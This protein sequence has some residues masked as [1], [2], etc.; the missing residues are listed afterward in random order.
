MTPAPAPA[1]PATTATT[2]TSTIKS[3]ADTDKKHGSGGKKPIVRLRDRKG[4]SFFIANSEAGVHET[5]TK[6]GPEEAVGATGQSEELATATPSP[7]PAD[8]SPPLEQEEE[9]TVQELRTFSAMAADENGN[10]TA[11]ELQIDTGA[12]GDWVSPAAVAAWRGDNPAAFP[13]VALPT[14][15]AHTAG[16][17]FPSARGVTV[18]ITVWAG[19]ATHEITTTFRILERA[20]ATDKVALIGMHCLTTTPALLRILVERIESTS[21]DQEGWVDDEEEGIDPPPPPP[22][23]AGELQREVAQLLDEFPDTFSGV[24]KQGGSDLP[25]M[26]IP[27]KADA[28][29]Q[30]TAP[31]G[32][33]PRLAAALMAKV[34]ELEAKGLVARVDPSRQ[35]IPRWC[36]PAMA[37]SKTDGTV[38]LV[39]DYSRTN[40]EIEYFAHPLPIQEELVARL[41]GAKYFSKIDLR[42]AFYQVKIDPASRHVTTFHTPGGLYQYTVSP[43]GLSLS[44]GWLQ[45]VIEELLREEILECAVAFLDDVVVYS[46][47]LEEHREHVRRVLRKFDSVSL[48]VNPAKC[49]FFQSK[50]TFLG[51][52]VDSST[53]SVSAD[54]C[55]DLRALA[56]PTNKKELKAL[57]GAFGFIRAFLPNYAAVAEPLQQRTYNVQPERIDASDP[58]YIAEI[59]ALKDLIASVPVL[60]HPRYDHLIELET[61]ASAEGWGAVLSQRIDGQK[62]IIAFA[63]ARFRGA[64]LRWTSQDREMA[65][66]V[67]AILRWKMFLQGQHFIVL[68]DCRNITFWSSPS[69]SL[70]VCRWREKLA[71]FQFSI[72]HVPGAQNITADVLSRLPPATSQL[73]ATQ[74][75]SRTPAPAPTTAE[76]TLFSTQE[77]TSAT[78]TIPPATTTVPKTAADTTAATDS[79][80]TATAQPH[81][82]VPRPSLHK[83]EEIGKAHNSLVGHG[84]VQKT[85]DLLRQRGQYWDDMHNDVQRFVAACNVCQKGNTV[86]P[87]APPSTGLPYE[88]GCYSVNDK[89]AIDLNV[90]PKDDDGYEYI[91]VMEDLFTRFVLLVPLKSKTAAEVTRALMQWAGLFGPPR[92]LL[93]DQGREFVSLMV[94][95]LLAMMGTTEEYTRAGDHRQNGIVE[96]S[97]REVNRHLLAIVQ[98]LNKRAS[99][100]EAVPVVQYIMNGSRTTATGIAPAELMFGPNYNAFQILGVPPSKTPKFKDLGALQTAHQEMLT[101]SARHIAELAKAKVARYDKRHPDGPTT[102][103]PD[104]W[105]LARWPDNRRPTKLHPHWRGPF[106]F[107]EHLSR[108]ES[109]L[110]DIMLGKDIIVHTSDLLA[111]DDGLQEDKLKIRAWDQHETPVTSI[112]DHKPKPLPKTLKDRQYL[113]RFR[114]GTEEWKDYLEVRDLEAFERYEA[115]QSGDKSASP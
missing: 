104:S 100:H 20:T 37:L 88:S 42:E 49:A 25:P 51:H 31:R 93:S 39:V 114:D 12:D 13:I 79:S 64:E 109:R 15:L 23:L 6:H 30:R 36:A 47:T 41:A 40:N 106:Q 59:D 110:R 56:T 115:N 3:P 33:A 29:P 105:V 80:N 86:G 112:V 77:G 43:M 91:A 11:A 52:D 1:G 55:A 65:A 21:A 66:V 46:E 7:G 84:G 96:R 111:Y 16:G 53:V 5:D 76:T 69:A 58:T 4:K 35:G 85:L 95:E 70:R 72:R 62:C 87:R 14:V 63:S 90:M 61:D 45:G 26:P 44:P 17:T 48:R 57:L 107:I 75:T 18:T 8:T 54:R 101:I 103:D 68:T 89:V 113:V 50:I 94:K 27:L 67:K 92:V 9:C 24:I 71:L 102:F 38:R 32:M 19:G 10:T 82:L 22:P 28:V 97:M 34:H 98:T 108:G 78:P 81:G 83:A 74:A 73:T 2:P 99:W 60:H